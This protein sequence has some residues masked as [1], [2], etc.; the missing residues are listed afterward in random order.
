MNIYLNSTEGNVNSNSYLFG[1][2]LVKVINIGSNK[3]KIQSINICSEEKL[4]YRLLVPEILEAS[5]E[6]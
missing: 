1:A 5:P 4:Q 3:T 6:G 2:S